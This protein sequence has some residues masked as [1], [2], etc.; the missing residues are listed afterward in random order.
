MN[1]SFLESNSCHIWCFLLNN[2]VFSC[3]WP[4]F[5]E[6]T[7]CSIL[8]FR[9]GLSKLVWV[10]IKPFKPQGRG[11]ML[12]PTLDILSIEMNPGDHWEEEISYS[13]SLP[14]QRLT[15]GPGRLFSCTLRKI[16][17]AFRSFLWSASVA[18]E[19]GICRGTLLFC[20][21]NTLAAVFKVV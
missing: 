4:F 20:L 18:S 1:S 2:G 14:D 3:I 12:N 15:A 5:T 6:G 7:V 17:S 8:G 21:K 9:L 19:V 11:S 13:W 10:P 16:S